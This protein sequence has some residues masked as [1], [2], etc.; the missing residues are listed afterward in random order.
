MTR[1]MNVSDPPQEPCALLR[2]E[3]VLGLFSCLLLVVNLTPSLL[4]V[5]SS[6][7]TRLLL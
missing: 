5:N 1:L 7:F 3:T 6:R 4:R 2:G